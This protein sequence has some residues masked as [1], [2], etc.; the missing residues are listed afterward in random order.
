MPDPAEF[1]KSK[2][3][4]PELGNNHSGRK[5]PLAL[6][7]QKSERAS[8]CKVSCD[9]QDAI[10]ASTKIPEPRQIKKTL[11]YHQIDAL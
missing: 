3:S 5:L 2:I 6:Q 9:P 1:F 7:T 8:L 11:I 10:A 4:T